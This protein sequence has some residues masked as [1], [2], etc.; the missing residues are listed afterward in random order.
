[1]TDYM[2]ANWDFDINP[3]KAQRLMDYLAENLK[4]VPEPELNDETAKAKWERLIDRGG[5]SYDQD[6]L[7]WRDWVLERLP[8]VQPKPYE[9]TKP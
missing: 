4:P 3:S 5:T 7:D 9:G 8:R 2:K 6:L 1:M